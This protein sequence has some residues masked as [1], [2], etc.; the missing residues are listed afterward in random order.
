MARVCMA[1]KISVAVNDG[2]GLVREA[3]LE[4][5]C[6]RKQQP[7]TAVGRDARGMQI[8]QGFETLK[9][10]LR[11]KD[12]GSLQRVGVPDCS[13][14]E[15]DGKLRVDGE[16]DAARKAESKNRRLVSLRAVRCATQPAG[17]VHV[18]PRGAHG[19]LGRGGKTQLEAAGTDRRH[20]GPIGRGTAKGVT[21]RFGIY[22]V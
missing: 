15:A 12:V 17:R 11:L 4:S 14:S 3:D 13:Q 21:G 10:R 5:R 1:G 8:N 20:K 9:H 18:V 7:D 19:T 16:S 22:G 2:A 6:R